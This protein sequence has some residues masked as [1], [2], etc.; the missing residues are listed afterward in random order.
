MCVELVHQPHNGHWTGTVASDDATTR[1]VAREG[2]EASLLCIFIM[3]IVVAASAFG[4][5]VACSCV[6]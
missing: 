2:G 5:G 4:F 6:A 3:I 1:G